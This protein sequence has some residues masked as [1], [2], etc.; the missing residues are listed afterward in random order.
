MFDN[1]E[2]CFLGFPF[3]QK[4]LQYDQN[5]LLIIYSKENNSVSSSVSSLLMN[6]TPASQ[7]TRFHNHIFAVVDGCQR[8]KVT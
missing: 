5:D 7:K 2:N 6:N 3:L 8:A 1:N 4:L